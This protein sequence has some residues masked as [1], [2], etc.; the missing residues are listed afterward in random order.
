[1]IDDEPDKGA[2]ALGAPAR[3]SGLLA[4]LLT[5]VVVAC[6]VQGL[7][8]GALG[9]RA[10]LIPLR[11]IELGASRGEVG[12]VFAA[13]TA[14][15][16]LV[17]IPS[18][19][20][21]ERWGLRRSLAAAFVLYLI[22][23]AIPGLFDQFAVLIVSMVLGGVAAAL[24]QNGLMAWMTAAQP[25]GT[26]AR[27][28]GWYT[29]AMQLGNTLGP[30]HRHWRRAKFLG[31][32]RLFFRYSS[33]DRVIIY[34]WVNDQNTLLKAGGRRSARFLLLPCWMFRATARASTICSQSNSRTPT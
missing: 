13:W 16:A 10:L 27:S 24:A 21:I 1:M 17:S 30:E 22:S 5:P 33:K 15:A 8:S 11:S 28:L 9:T 3:G 32:F 31:R 4:S 7:C 29:L 2:R 23:Q 19:A 14:T 18:A 34:A 26:V 6:V 20:A 25:P 12:L